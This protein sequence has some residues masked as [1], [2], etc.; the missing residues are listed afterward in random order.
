MNNVD[1]F[2]GLEIRPTDNGMKE[3]DI[4]SPQYDRLLTADEIAEI[5]AK[6]AENGDT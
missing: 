4:E 5:I 6:G 2:S 3:G 1:T